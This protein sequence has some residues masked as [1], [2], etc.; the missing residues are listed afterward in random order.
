MTSS[1]ASPRPPTRRSARRSA[2]TCAAAPATTRSSR[3]SARWPHDRAA[4]VARAH[5]R[6]VP[7]RA[8]PHG[9]RDRPRRPRADARRRPALRRRLPAGDRRA[10]SRRCSP[11]RS[12]TRRSRGRTSRRRCRRS[13]R[14]RRCG[15]ARSRRA[16]RA[17]SSP[18]ATPT[19]SACRAASGSRRAAAR[20]SGT[21][22][23]SSS[24]SREQPWCDGN[25][26]M[27][28]ISG[29]RR[30]AGPRRAAAA[31]GLK[32]IFPFDPRGAYGT[33]GGFREEYPGGV[34]ALFRYLVG[35]FGVVHEHRGAPG[36]LPPERE[37]LW[38][39]G[40]G[41]PGLPDVP[42]HLQRRHDEGPDLRSLYFETLI[43]PFE[44][45]KAPSSAA[46][47]ASERSRSRPTRDRAGTATRTRRTCSDAQSYWRHLPTSPK[48][49]LLHGPCPPRAAV[50][51][52]P[53]RDAALVRPLAEGH[54]HRRHGRAAG[55][56]L[57]HRRERV[58]HRRR[59]G[60]RRRSSGRSSI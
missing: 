55:A 14:G 48:K 35:H 6:R 28:G 16:T 47:R 54:R 34:A 38:R 3:R 12:T 17:S 2:A 29:L 36:E 60:R 45:P 43:D 51:R 32:A 23:T 27:I 30:G 25:V 50:P 9:A 40:D 39:G 44:Q 21:R 24:G 10:A 31:A 13:P 19:S 18:A 53:R 11:S 15:R 56:V 49:L 26:G 52:S 22:T 7:P 57:G 37:E 42:E 41:E 59:T 5:P 4:P 8:Q 46:R 20:A 58:A 1:S 33:L